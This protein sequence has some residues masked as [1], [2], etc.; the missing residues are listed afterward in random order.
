LRKRIEIQKTKKQFKNK[1]CFNWTGASFKE[2][3]ERGNDLGTAKGL[4]KKKKRGGGS[5]EG[6]PEGGGGPD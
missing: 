3:W 1:T 2:K 4:E 6:I 5:P